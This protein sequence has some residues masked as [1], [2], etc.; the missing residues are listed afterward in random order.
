MEFR[1]K[2]RELKIFLEKTNLR[3]QKISAAVR[4]KN[5]NN[6]INLPFSVFQKADLDVLHQVIQD[7]V[8]KVPDDRHN[9]WLLNKLEDYFELLKLRPG[10][11]IKLTC[12][13]EVPIAVKR[14]ME[15]TSPHRWVFKEGEDG[16]LLPWIITSIVYYPRKR[17]KD[18]VEEEHVTFNLTAYKKGHRIISNETVYN[19]PTTVDR[20]IEQMGYFCETPVTVKKYVE[21]MDRYAQIQGKVGL[22]M[23]AIG[24]AYVTASGGWSSYTSVESMVRDGYPS[25]VVIDNMNPEVVKDDKHDP[26]ILEVEFW[27]DSPNF[28]PNGLDLAKAA[29]VKK[30][31]DEDDDDDEQTEV[32]KSVECALPQHPYLNVFDL[33]KHRWVS[34]HAGNLQEYPWDKQLIDKLII[35]EKQKDLLKILISTTG[36][37]TEDIIRGKMAGVIVLATGVPGTGKTLTA[38]VFSEFIERPLYNVQCS[39]LGLD[40]ESIESN[41][42]EV[43]KRAQRWSAV[44][45][46]DEADVYVR[47]RERDIQQNA[48]VG[49]FLRL[50]EYYKGVLF[51][52]SNLGGDIDDAVKSRATAWIQYDL[53]GVR[54][55][56]DIW[57]VLGTQFKAGLSD[58]S[59]ATLVQKLP[60][61]SGRSVRNILK[62]ATTLEGEVT[63][64]RIL[65]C[66]KY[67]A[68]ETN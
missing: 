31:D 24:D 26:P 65:E 5:D 33:E 35:P 22:Q 18:W 12:L 30:D 51:M 54:E 37:R 27:N 59:I 16:M 13:N 42:G 32:E 7:R 46:I 40:V 43:L 53:P 10:P 17:R 44:L 15:A 23:L 67:Q 14:F 4:W 8:K 11:V 34:I 21:Q 39:Q 66:S 58:K 38:E 2:V 41:L 63:V 60:N 45:I 47:R 50:L 9:K 29:A 68:L 36:K 19:H 49:V 20:L 57:R 1:V 28:D 56:V 52:T 64:E 25:K 48:I 61:I 62:L 55:L 6:N 3:N